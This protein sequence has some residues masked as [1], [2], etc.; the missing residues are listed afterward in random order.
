PRS[1]LPQAVR[2]ALALTAQN[3]GDVSVSVAALQTV[4][5]SAPERTGE[6]LQ[7]LER[8][9]REDPRAAE[10]R[11]MLASIYLDRRD[12]AA[13][14]AELS[15]GGTV[16]TALLER[17]LAKY[18]AILK[19]A[20]DDAAARLGYIQA[21]LMAR[22]FDR[23]LELGQEMLKQADDA[24]AVRLTLA[25]G[26]ALRDKGDHD[27]A[28]K[29]Y[30]AAYG[31]DRS[32]AGTIV[33]RLRDLLQ[34]EGT[35]ALASLA[36]GKVLGAE[37][38]S[39]EAVEA[40]RAAGAADPKLQE[41]VYNEL[42]T[43]MNTC[44]GDPQPGLALLGHLK[45]ARDTQRALQV[46]SGLLDAHPQLAG[47]L[48]AHIETILASEPNL[49]FAHY[50][51][52][53][54]LQRMQMVPRSAASFLNA[55]RQDAGMAPMVLKRLQE[56]ILLAPSSPEPYLVTC[57]I[58]ASRG[59]LTAAAET[60]QKALMRIPAEADRLVPR[61]EEIWKQHRGN[62]QIAMAF[63][64]V[65]RRAGRHD[66]AIQAYGDA[67]SKDSA[68]FDAAFEGFE[69]IV[70]ERPDLGE[71]YLARGRAHAQRLRIDPALADLEQACRLDPKLLPAVLQETEALRAR[72]PESYA[73]L[74]LI[75]DLCVAGGR[76]ADARRLLE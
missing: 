7:A 59:K 36:L 76:D 37:G 24:S 31:R 44:P 16:N 54:A 34:A 70:A 50:E 30:F 26:D 72:M 19:A 6:V 32:V 46:I 69:A 45:E 11:Y 27:A 48:V 71:A 60:I 40:L 73:C 35:Q 56:L 49:G 58:H 21:L 75:A 13:A 47:A 55:F 62:P 12:H 17:V 74:I 53:R 9:D 38:R 39:S 22:Q 67:A 23:V 68:L 64:E 14:E 1:P 51:M 8:F 4:L 18:E 66:K 29:R 33:S 65:C 25:I 41:T 3:G 20:P 2:F 57:A 15:R 63:A 52:G 42:Q 43:L 28:A 61:L 5:E 10:A